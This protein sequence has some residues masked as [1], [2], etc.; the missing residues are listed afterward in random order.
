MA[1][2]A[3][4]VRGIGVRILGREQCGLINHRDSHGVLEARTISTP[5]YDGK[6][7]MISVEV[8]VQI[9]LTIA[10][11]YRLMARILLFH[12]GEEGS[13]PSGATDA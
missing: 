3:V 5:L 1:R 11:P 9:L 12:S 8:W 13:K 4:L 6:G 10:W 7:R 2:H